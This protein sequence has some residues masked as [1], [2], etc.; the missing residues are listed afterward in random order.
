MFLQNSKLFP[1]SKNDG[2][3]Y[4]AKKLMSR[5]NTN[6]LFIKILHW[7]NSANKNGE[8]TRW[9]FIVLLIS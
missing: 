3:L 9:P 5:W 2:L 7:V 1:L 6:P 8:Q 4:S